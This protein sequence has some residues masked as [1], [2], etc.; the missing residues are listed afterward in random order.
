MKNRGLNPDGGPA[1]PMFRRAQA[2]SPRAFLR[3]LFSHSG[4]ALCHYGKNDRPADPMLSVSHVGH[5]ASNEEFEDRFVSVM[6]RRGNLTEKMFSMLKDFF[7][8]AGK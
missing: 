2:A 5:H 4:R 7:K 8:E 1:L 3:T 6:G